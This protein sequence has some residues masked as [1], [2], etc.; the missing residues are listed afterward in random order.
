MS[1]LILPIDDTHAISYALDRLHAGQPIAFPTDTVYGIGVVAFDVEAILRLYA[2]K[3]RPR[4]QAIPVLLADAADVSSVAVQVSSAAVELAERYWPGALSLVL[5]A[6]AHLS[7][8]LLANKE[9]VAVRVPDHDWLRQLICTLGKPLAATSANL[10]GQ[11]DCA[12]AADVLAQL[13]SSLSLVIDGGPT[14][15]TIP[16]TIVD[17]TDTEPRI[18][19]QG[20]LTV[21]AASGTYLRS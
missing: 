8:E 6:A 13:G 17:C 7:M 9:S 5:P 2:V 20:A 21:Q 19:R 4:S 12:T 1:A 10:H 3:Q 16:S 14:P 18:L 15:G 11:G